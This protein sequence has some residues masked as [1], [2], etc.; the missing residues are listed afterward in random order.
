VPEDQRVAAGLLVQ[1]VA[2]AG[3][4]RVST[5]R[6]SERPRAEAVDPGDRVR[7]GVVAVGE[8]GEQ[9]VQVGRPLGVD[10]DP[11]RLDRAH[12][13][14]RPEHH[15]GEPHAAGGR[16]EQLG[17]AV[18]PDGAHRAVGDEQVEPLDGVAEAA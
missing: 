5:A 6:P 14:G 12:A 18:R 7:V 2:R 3:R 9:V 11:G 8:A 15:P 13:Q 4:P 17:V 10:D 16:P 1:L